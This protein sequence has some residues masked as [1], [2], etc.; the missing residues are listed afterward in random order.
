MDG[1]G[2]EKRR[3]ETPNET[4]M[5]GALI[6]N[7][8]PPLFLKISLEGCWESAVEWRDVGT[9][10]Y[11][12]EWKTGYACERETMTGTEGSCMVADDA[13]GSFVYDLTSLRDNGPYVIPGR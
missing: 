1:G 4:Q 2:R 8:T 13:I 3:G 7:Q 6:R 11:V 10:R 5:A 9:F 12:F